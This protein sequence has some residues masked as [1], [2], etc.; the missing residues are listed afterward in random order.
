MIEQLKKK[1]TSSILALAFMASINLNAQTWTGATDTDFATATN[2][3]TGVA[4]GA[5]VAVTINPAT[6]NPVVA[7][8]TTA[9]CS[10]LGINA[11]GNLTIQ[12]SLTPSAASYTGG[13]ILID[14]GNLNIR[15]N[16]NFGVTNNPATVTVN[17]GTLNAR[18]AL[19]VAEKGACTLNINGGVVSVDQSSN[20]NTVII[21]GYYAHGIVNLNGGIL[22]TNPLKV[23]TGALAIQEQ[24]TRS[25]TGVLNIN[26]GTLILTGDQ[27]AFIDG[28]VTAGKIVPGAGKSIVVTLV[29]AVVADPTATPPVVAS[30]AETRVTASASLGIDSKTL[31]NSVSVYPNP[32]TGVITV[33]SPVAVEAIT[34][35]DVN[36]SQILSASKTNSVD[37]SN[38][39]SGLYFV[40]VQ[41]ENGTTTKK[42]MVK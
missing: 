41:T 19:I 31:D 29:P 16:A 11:G 33:N 40:K 28:Y 38:Q 22:R 7:T 35:V 1:R 18:N 26:G 21:G 8:G 3:D 2:W 37:L 39:S 5:G 34:V 23:G 20:G 24:P 13:T 42:V 27:K 30:A 10:T 36:G 25:G 14:G 9:V 6:N 12:G 15:N 32:T 17:S 4:P